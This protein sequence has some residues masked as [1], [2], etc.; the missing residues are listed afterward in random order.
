MLGAN[1]NIAAQPRISQRRIESAWEMEN[2]NPKEPVDATKRIMEINND[3]IA[4]LQG[5]FLKV[6]ESCRAPCE[7]LVIT[8]MP[9]ETPSFFVHPIT[10]G[11][12]RYIQKGPNPPACRQFQSQM[13]H[14]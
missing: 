11:K 5:W 1:R 3:D 10:A 14:D 8:A 6:S 4:S 7:C 13:V 2:F 9:N 12:T